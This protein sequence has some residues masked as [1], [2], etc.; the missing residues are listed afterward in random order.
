MGM[1][2]TRLDA[3]G[4]RLRRI[5]E[6]RGRKLVECHCQVRRL[7]MTDLRWWD[8][9][10]E[11]RQDTF[12]I[13]QQN[14]CTCGGTGF[15]CAY[16]KGLR[17]LIRRDAENHLRPMFCPQCSQMANGLPTPNEWWLDWQKFAMQSVPAYQE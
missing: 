13:P 8:Y 6:Y 17:I 2:T 4:L 7:A 16:C 11:E 1:D 12:W 10:I 15:L 3:N 9:A 14:T 5:T